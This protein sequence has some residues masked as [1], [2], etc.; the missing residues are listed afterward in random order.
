[1]TIALNLDTAIVLLTPIYIDIARRTGRDPLVL[2]ASTVLLACLASSVLPVSNLTNLIA[3]EQTGATAADFVAHL[4]L[5]AAVAIGVGWWCYRWRFDPDRRVSMPIE[6]V[7]SA[8]PP[9]PAAPGRSTTIGFVLLT[10]VVFGFVLGPTVGAPAWTV[11]VAADVVIFTVLRRPLRPADIPLGTAAAVASIGV[12][13]AGAAAALH[14]SRLIAGTNSLA[15][16]RTIG[17][18]ALGANVLNNLP[19]L[20]V[21]LPATGD[22]VGPRT[23]AVLIGVNMGPVVLVTGSLASM[24]WLDAL[25]RFG[26][27]AT[28]RDFTRIGVSVGL[29][30]ALAGAATFLGAARLM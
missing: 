26:V 18:T 29:P 4:A 28:A 19:A 10:A 24:L 23:W 17:A 13:A 2:A 22:G 9:N 3:V 8:S 14:T 20:L 27:R 16:A 15:L 30:A 12:L 5:P 1:M 7:G 6:H 11:A 21:A 25:N